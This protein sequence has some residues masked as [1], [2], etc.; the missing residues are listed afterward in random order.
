MNVDDHRG[1]QDASQRA[2]NPSASIRTY[3]RVI[4]L[5]TAPTSRAAGPRCVSRNVAVH[6]PATRGLTTCSPTP[7]DI[8]EPASQVNDR[9]SST[10]VTVYV[11]V[12]NRGWT[13][14]TRS[15][16]A[17]GPLRDRRTDETDA[18][19]PGQLSTSLITAHTTGAG[20]SM[21]MLR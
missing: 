4:R 18:V 11:S 1:G 2:F 7:R 20:A 13:T 5:S 10:A 3:R 12:G 17:S 6:P 21:S 16:T 15:P 19:H 14:T 9:P 8:A